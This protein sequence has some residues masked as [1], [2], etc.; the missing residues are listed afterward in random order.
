MHG[1]SGFQAFPQ[2]R[3]AITEALGIM[4][5]LGLQEDEQYGSMLSVLG[6]LDMDQRY[7]EALEIY[8]KA[9]AVL[10]HT[11]NGTITGCS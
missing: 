3:K 4:D 10:V 9:K 5:E 11:R 1:A 6:N 2:A 8:D 7:K